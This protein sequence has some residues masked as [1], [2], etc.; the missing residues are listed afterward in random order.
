[1][2]HVK[3]PD[4]ANRIDAFLKVIDL[5]Q[6]SD[7]LDVAHAA[8]LSAVQEAARLVSDAARVAPRSLRRSA[9]VDLR[10][11]CLRLAADAADPAARHPTPLFPHHAK[12]KQAEED[13]GSFAAILIGMADAFSDLAGP[14]PDG[15][16]PEPAHEAR[17]IDNVVRFPRQEASRWQ[18]DLVK[19]L[20]S[21]DRDVISDADAF[22][23]TNAAIVRDAWVATLAFSCAAVHAAD[24]DC[25]D[26]DDWTGRI[27]EGTK[28]LTRMFE[29][30]AH[31]KRT[32]ADDGFT[33]GA[34]IAL[35]ELAPVARA[36]SDMADEARKRRKAESWRFSWRLLSRGRAGMALP[37]IRR[38]VDDAIARMVERT[39]D[40]ADVAPRLRNDL[41][42]A[43][44]SYAGEWATS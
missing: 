44:A 19:A 29:L 23:A 1:M 34:L 40:C 18:A 2:K 3:S 9:L 14:A 28:A 41:L 42:A 26:L 6:A 8:R 15:S 11:A 17:S 16:P 38:A 43:A 13:H 5:T 30:L 7:G 12:L 25:V 35:A 39:P 27:G 31:R 32:G 20:G 10:H 4:T 36:G 33:D 24:H 22:K 37:E 21:L